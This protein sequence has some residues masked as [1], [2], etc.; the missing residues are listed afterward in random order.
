MEYDDVKFENLTSSQANM[1]LNWWHNNYSL[2]RLYLLGINKTEIRGSKMGNHQLYET[3]KFN[4]FT[5]SCLSLEKA[6]EISKLFGK[7]VTL[8]F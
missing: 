5:I 8:C 6:T 1:F 4:P 2:R 7:E 3:L